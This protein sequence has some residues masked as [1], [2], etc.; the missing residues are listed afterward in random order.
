MKVKQQGSKSIEFRP[1]LDPIPTWH[2]VLSYWDSKGVP[3]VEIV[4][5]DPDEHDYQIFW[6][7]KSL[8]F[9]TRRNTFRVLEKN[10]AGDTA[11]ALIYTVSKGR[12]SLFAAFALMTTLHH[13]NEPNTLTVVVRQYLDQVSPDIRNHWH[14]NAKYLLPC[15]V[16]G[17]SRFVED[18]DWHLR[19]D[20]AARTWTELAAKF[21]VVRQPLLT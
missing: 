13:L 16:D 2:E 15:V 20:L 4:P 17:G 10:P 12:P 6:F 8:R 1:A 21:Q 5:Y 3:Q 7:E 19:V 9:N 18:R 11:R 14:S